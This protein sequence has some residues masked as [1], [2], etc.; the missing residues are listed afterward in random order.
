MSKVNVHKWSHFLCV[1]HMY[2]FIWAYV[3]N[4][5]LPHSYITL[6][7]SMSTTQKN[8]PFYF[9]NVLVLLKI[10]HWLI[11]YGWKETWT[12]HLENRKQMLENFFFFSLHHG[13]A[14]NPKMSSTSWFYFS[15]ITHAHSIS[16]SFSVLMISYYHI[17]LQQS[18]KFWSQKVFLSLF[19]DTFQLVTVDH[20]RTAVLFYY[21]EN[22]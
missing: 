15:L 8:F 13:Y 4:Q 6:F 19:T 20:H 5:L 12:F 2:E 18:R 22:I 11:H 16:E 10:T 7:G 9:E 21:S 3:S 1:L 17:H 14:H